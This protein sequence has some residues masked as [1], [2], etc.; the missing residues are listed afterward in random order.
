MVVTAIIVT[1]VALLLWPH[2]SRALLRLQAL[3]ALSARQPYPED[4]TTQPG[5]HTRDLVSA[6]RHRSWLRDWLSEFLPATR[7][8]R[9]PPTA[10][11]AWTVDLLG[12]LFAAGLD[13]ATALRA[14]GMRGH[15]PTARAFAEAAAAVASGMPLSAVF[16]PTAHT[17]E[18]VHRIGVALQRS[19]HS[20][21]AITESLNRVSTWA[22]NQAAT[23][24]QAAAERAGVMIAGP[25][26]ACFLP[27]F[28]CIGIAPVIAGLASRILPEVLP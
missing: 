7:H 13:P 25:L 15:S 8:R 3:Q 20:G 11:D 22:R 14:A 26:G 9:E 19:T 28:V 24:A 16:A 5:A 18:T 1:A 12:A 6:S 23:R 10:A 27:A 21:S 4:N 2:E 17:P